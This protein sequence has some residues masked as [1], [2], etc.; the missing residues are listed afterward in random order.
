MSNEDTET[1]EEINYK[2]P[3]KN[4]KSS[5]WEVVRFIVIALIIVGPIRIFIAQP[6]VVSGTSMDPTFEDAEYL[7]VD[8]ISYHLGHPDRG[9]VAI[10]RFPLD[11][12]KFFIKRIIGLPNETITLKDGKV[13]VTTADGE[14]FDLDEPYIV[15]ED[16]K[17]NETFQTEEGEYFAMGDNRLAS[18]D[19]RSWGILPEKNIIGKAFVRLLPVSHASINPGYFNYED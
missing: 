1:Q 12:S 14:T 5:F 16:I 9:E 17:D 15:H 8:Q 6:F 18:L 10:F 4:L 7:I 2:Q 19:S 11:P 13:T 3:E